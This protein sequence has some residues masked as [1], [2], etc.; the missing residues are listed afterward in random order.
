MG[1]LNSARQSKTM[2]ALLDTA[3]SQDFRED[4]LLEGYR[5]VSFRSRFPLEAGLDATLQLPQLP[6][7]LC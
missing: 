3:Y 1:P 7:P 5:S 6:F 4:S 2:V